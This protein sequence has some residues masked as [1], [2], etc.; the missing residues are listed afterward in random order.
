MDDSTK[1]KG[2][3]MTAAKLA[4]EKEVAMKKAGFK[5]EVAEKIR[6]ILDEARK[7]WPLGPKDFDEDGVESEILDLF[8]E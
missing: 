1:P 3:Q 4:K 7:E 2:N 6:A 5:Y 8:N